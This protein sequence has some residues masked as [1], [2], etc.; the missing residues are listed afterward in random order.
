M[1]RRS[2]SVRRTPRHAASSDG[3]FVRVFGSFGADMPTL[4]LIHGL[5]IGEPSA[6]QLLAGRLP[7][8]T[9]SGFYSLVRD[10][11]CACR[12]ASSAW[13]TGGYVLPFRLLPS[14]LD[15]RNGRRAF[16]VVGVLNSPV[17][18][19]LNSCRN[20][21]MAQFGKKPPLEREFARTVFPPTL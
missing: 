19:S 13:V 7:A 10:R 20:Y 14:I 12:F 5:G 3:M 21:A 4:V 16:I 17:T 9:Y 15:S 8:P 2:V 11:R 1:M 6:S 18:K